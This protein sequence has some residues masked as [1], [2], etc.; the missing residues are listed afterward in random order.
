MLTLFATYI[1]RRTIQ[2][3]CQQCHI[4]FDVLDMLL[5]YRE[6]PCLEKMDILFYAITLNNLAI[7]NDDS[8]WNYLSFYSTCL[9]SLAQCEMPTDEMEY[10]MR[11]SLMQT[12]RVSVAVL[13][14]GVLVIK[15]VYRKSGKQ[16]CRCSLCAQWHHFYFARRAPRSSPHTSRS[17]SLV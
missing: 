11:E 7:V 6:L 10:S 9:V 15:K 5:K 3:D 4:R 2:L 1:F 17:L 16:S 13:G 14:R 8:I 12:R